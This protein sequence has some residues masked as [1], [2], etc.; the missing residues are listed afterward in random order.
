M[1]DL[2]DVI[3]TTIKNLIDLP[4]IRQY[5]DSIYWRISVYIFSSLAYGVSG[6][7]TPGWAINQS[8]LNIGRK[9]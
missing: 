5:R 2:F 3:L 8:V 4:F 7:S 6:V 1:H 9:R